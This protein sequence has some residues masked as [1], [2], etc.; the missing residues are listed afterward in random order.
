[1]INIQDRNTVFYTLKKLESN[2]PALF[3]KMNAQHMIEHLMLA[4]SFSNGTS[5]QFL[6]VDERIAKMIK[7]HTINT[8]K[9]MS[10]GFKAPMLGDDVLPLFHPNL[11]IAVEHLKK[12]LNDF[13]LYFKL[14]PDSKPISPVVGELNQKEWIIFHN[15]HFTHHFKQFGLL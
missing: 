6:M 2:T 9:E 11:E 10:I 12:E 1:M 7:H 15:K 14:N 8:T 4:L 13:D 5:P 3:G